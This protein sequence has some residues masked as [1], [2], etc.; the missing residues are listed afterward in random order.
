M[1][2]ILEQRPIS[3]PEV[4]SILDKLMADQVDTTEE[5][6]IPEAEGGG[7]DGVSDPLREGETGVTELSEEAEKRFYL[8]STHEYARLFSKMEARVAKIVVEKLVEEEGI[9]RSIAIQIV[10]INADTAEELGLLFEK[11]SKRL[12]KDELES[13][14]FKIREYKEL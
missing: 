4:K 8:H 6:V 10:N 5:P 11:G 13:L 9:D 3:I 14:L 12:S 2:E 7:E 1:R